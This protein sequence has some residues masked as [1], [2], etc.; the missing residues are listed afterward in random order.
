MIADADFN[1]ILYGSFELIRHLQIGMS[2]YYSKTLKGML[3]DIVYRRMMKRFLHQKVYSREWRNQ[4]NTYFYRKSG[5]VDE[6]GRA[7]Y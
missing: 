4:I 3:P 2:Y 6:K 5:I 1:G 7:V